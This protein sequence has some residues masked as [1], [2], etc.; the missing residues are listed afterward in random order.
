MKKKFFL[1][2]GRKIFKRPLI[3]LSILFLCVFTPVKAAQEVATSDLKIEIIKIKD[4]GASPFWSPDGK[5]IVYVDEGG[6]FVISSSGSGEE[7][8]I[9]SGNV[10][11][12]RWSPDGKYIAYV[13]RKG[14]NII[15]PY[16]SGQPNLI[17]PD[18]DVQ[19]PVWSP[20]SKWI[21]F[22]LSALKGEEGSGVL[23]VN[24]ETLKSRQL[25]YTG[26]NPCFSGDGKS[27]LYF[28][29]D[30]K[31]K[32]FGQL[33][34]ADLYSTDSKKLAPIGG[35]CMNFNLEGSFL[36]FAPKKKDG[37]SL[38]I[39]IASPFVDFKY[40]ELPKLSD[41]GYFPSFS[42]DGKWVSF[43]KYDPKVKKTK[44]YITPLSYESPLPRGGELIDVAYG[45]YPRWAFNKKA[46]VYE[47][48]G[49][50]GGIYVA[51]I[52]D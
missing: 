36:A 40:D 46:L 34:S 19:M 50:R 38:G 35:V 15:S 52:L 17:Y 24:I 41:D 5:E 48:L 12:P 2:S 43:F 18:N 1:S 39:Y 13:N 4:S 28:T 47:M 30:E 25:S 20:D 26:I 31:S 3:I 51:K 11:E 21:T 8:K 6:L 29:D 9:V 22:Y 45:I 42:F 23:A 44:I 16:K 10:I 33:I 49:V 32:G 7:R 37:T 27:V 14:L